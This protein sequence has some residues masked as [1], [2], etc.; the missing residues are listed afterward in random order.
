M[1]STLFG[2]LLFIVLLAPGSAYTLR[3]ERVSSQQ[4]LSAFRETV[5]LVFASVLADAAVLCAFAFLR[6][7]APAMTP[8]AGRLIRSPRVYATTHYQLVAIWATGLLA[9]AILL[10]WTAA[11]GRVRRTA[12]RLLTAG[13][14]G[15]R[16]SH[17]AYLSAW[18]LMF[19]E[20]PGKRIHV[21]CLLEDGSYVAGRLWSFSRSADDHP[22]RELTIMG[23][24]T[25]RPAHASES[26]ELPNV[27][28]AA[29]SARR[30]TLLTVSYLKD[31]DHGDSG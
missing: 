18:W 14:P 9:T 23:P 13:T 22:D 3:R 28:A 6:T 31:E 17:P 19:A 21:G 1:P 26:R 8:D 7:L 20:H 16:P 30:I 15:T 10:A 12:L 24:V 29:V 25:Y 5:Q 27:S 11:G 4:S 2:L